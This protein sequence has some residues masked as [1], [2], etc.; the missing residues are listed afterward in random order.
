MLFQLR[1]KSNIV[2]IS[3]KKSFTTSTTVLQVKT[4]SLLE[5][6]AKIDKLSDIFETSVWSSCHR[7]QDAT[8]T[9]GSG[10]PILSWLKSVVRTFDDDADAGTNAKKS[11]PNIFSKFSFYEVTV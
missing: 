1:G 2:Q 8:W 4:P 6:I 5:I 9:K 11:M 7:V 3:S 10:A